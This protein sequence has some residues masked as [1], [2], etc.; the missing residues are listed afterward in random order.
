MRCRFSISDA[1]SPSS[2]AARRCS[3]ASASEP[4]STSTSASPTCRSPVVDSG[5]PGVDSAVRERVLEEA[6]R[7]VGAATPERDAGEHDGH[8]EPVGDVAGRA[9]VARRLAERVGRNRQVPGGPGGEPE[10]A[11]RRP[12]HEV[13]VRADEVAGPAR[14]GGR[15]GDVA[16]GLGDGGP[17]DLDH[18]R[19][20]R[21]VLVASLPRVDRT[22]RRR[23]RPRPERRLGDVEPPVE[24]VEVTLREPRPREVHRQQRPVSYDVLRQGAQPLAHR[25]VLAALSHPG[26]GELHQVGGLVVVTAGEGVPDGVGQAVVLGVPVAASWCRR[27]TCSVP[28]AVSRA[29]SASAKRWW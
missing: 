15:P 5:G 13:V 9:D 16:A 27:P 10:E 4:C 23:G 26:H 17:V 28:P 21:Q 14:V 6:P 12:E 7:L 18:G 11:R 1:R 8:P 22:G 3:S 25:P 2:A 19:Q 20:G 24:P 29:R